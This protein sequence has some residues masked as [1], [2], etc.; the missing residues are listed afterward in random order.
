M[1]GILNSVRDLIFQLPV[2]IKNESSSTKD[3]DATRRIDPLRR[4]NAKPLLQFVGLQRQNL[5]VFSH[6]FMQHKTVGTNAD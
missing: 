5:N 2:L 4:N 3:P 6:G 1:F